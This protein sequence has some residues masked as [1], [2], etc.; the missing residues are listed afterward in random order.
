MFDGDGNLIEMCQSRNA[1]IAKAAEQIGW[2]VTAKRV[3]V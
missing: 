3:K 1:A 2:T